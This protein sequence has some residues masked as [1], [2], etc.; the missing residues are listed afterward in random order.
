MEIPD[1]SKPQGALLRVEWHT[2]TIHQATVMGVSFQIT[3]GREGVTVFAGGA[4][5]H[6]WQAHA[7][8]PEVLFT[9]H[10]RQ[11]SRI[12]TLEVADA[13]VAAADL[14]SDLWRDAL[15]FGTQL[16]AAWESHKGL[17]RGAT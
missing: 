11:S 15:P 7:E 13:M 5:M 10:G 16:T 3:T 6:S 2:M 4:P 9:D 8:R 1:L 17:V 14:R 12:L